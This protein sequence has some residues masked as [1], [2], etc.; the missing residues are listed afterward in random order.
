MLVC[1]YK[2]CH[3]W[4]GGVRRK[5]AFRP[6]YSGEDTTRKRRL[7][8]VLK[9]N[10]VEPTDSGVREGASRGA[11]RQRCYRS[12]RCAARRCTRIKYTVDVVRTTVQVSV[13]ILVLETGCGVWS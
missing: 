3:S 11:Y 6:R 10:L 4:F 12:H 8:R 5:G 7:L 2:G 13:P 9:S 1:L